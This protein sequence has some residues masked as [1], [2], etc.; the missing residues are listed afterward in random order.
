MR[1][2]RPAR[3]LLCL[4]AAALL[5]GYSAPSL[6]AQ[7]APGARSDTVGESTMTLP[8]DVYP[9]SGNRLPLI[10]R[11]D[12]KEEDQQVYDMVV[13][14]SRSLVGLRGPGGIRLHSPR[15]AEYM[16]KPNDYLRFETGLGRRLSELAILVTAR[17]L[18]QQF[19]W[20]AHEPAAIKAGLEQDIIE[21]VK[22]RR[23]VAGVGEKEAAIIE[24]GRQAVGRRKVSPETF[25][26]ALKL[27]D[28]ETLVNLV[29]LMGYYAATAVLLDTFDQHLAPG[30]EPL[31]PVPER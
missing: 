31:L 17:E 5:G 18:D 25:A 1:S 4:T 10:K 3:V 26:R 8:K 29:S 13:G 27:F 6:E 24:L 14:D 19:E 12:L 28:S 16:R 7:E 22:H 2:N 20:T 21:V 9:D 15:L 23:P 30:Q 11:E